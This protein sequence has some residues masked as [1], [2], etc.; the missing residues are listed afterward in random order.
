MKV[1]LFPGYPVNLGVNLDKHNSMG[2]LYEANW[3]D[4]S[5]R[6]KQPLSILS[7]SNVNVSNLGKYQNHLEQIKSFEASQK[8]STVTL[9]ELQGYKPSELKSSKSFHH[10]GEWDNEPR[11][12]ASASTKIVQNPLYNHAQNNWHQAEIDSI[13]NKQKIEPKLRRSQTVVVVKQPQ[14]QSQTLSENYQDIDLKEFYRRRYQL[15]KQQ[16]QEE[17]PSNFNPHHHHHHHNHGV[18]IDHNGIQKICDSVSKT[19]NSL[20]RNNSSAQA[21]FY[22]TNDTVNN[23]MNC[24]KFTPNKGNFDAIENEALNGGKRVLLNPLAR[25]HSIK[26]NHFDTP[27]KLNPAEVDGKLCDFEKKVKKKNSFSRMFYNTISFGRKNRQRSKLNLGE[28]SESSTENSNSS[29][30]TLST[31][32]ITEFNANN[33][34]DSEFQIPRPR[35]IV[36]VHTYARKRRTG[37]LTSESIN[38]NK[39]GG[40]I[41]DRNA[42]SKGKLNAHELCLCVAR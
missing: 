5:E 30:S 35:L 36:P 12:A 6:I 42:G 4:T 2:L 22:S 9:R 29:V 13:N 26:I 19:N 18:S 16:Q 28:I 37:N 10:H 8:S 27:Q 31:S 14:L 20:H 7:K 38:N 39:D 3:T 1:K 34:K 24:Y 15:Q 40:K 41:C 32:S 17:S 23:R 33:V 21:S 11:R 25:N